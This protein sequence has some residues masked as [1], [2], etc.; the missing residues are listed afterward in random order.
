MKKLLLVFGFAAS[1]MV[2]H[3]QKTVLDSRLEARFSKEEL[4]H[5]EQE[6]PKEL[7]FLNYAIK[8]GHYLGM[9]ATDKKGV[10]DGEVELMNMDYINIYELGLDYKEDH[11]QYFRIKN[12]TDKV[13]VVMPRNII[14]EEM[15][16]VKK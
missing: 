12:V 4:I 5:M 2:V 9:Y 11:F 8:N 1:M 14:L 3:A 16:R 15:R 6:N 13:L 7:S 10:I